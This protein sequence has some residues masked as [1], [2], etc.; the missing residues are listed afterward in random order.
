[1][2]KRKTQQEIVRDQLEFGKHLTSKKAILYFNIMRLASVIT[3]LKN[4]GMK[5]QTEYRVNE[6]GGRYAV[7][8]I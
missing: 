2:K 7:Y 3:A 8:F 1:M 4:K 5:I 6:I